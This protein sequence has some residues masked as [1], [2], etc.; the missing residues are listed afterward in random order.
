MEGKNTSKRNDVGN[1]NWVSQDIYKR[2]ED[3]NRAVL[4]SRIALVFLVALTE[5]R[6]ARGRHVCK[7]GSEVSWDALSISGLRD[8]PGSQIHP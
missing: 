7:V 8:W 3:S 2:W 5:M 6:H 4:C 1:R